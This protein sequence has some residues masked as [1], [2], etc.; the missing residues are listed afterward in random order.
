MK[1]DLKEIKQYLEST[2]EEFSDVYINYGI[3][4]D[5]E[6]QLIEKALDRVNE[7]LAENPEYRIAS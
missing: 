4:M 7:L 1:K 5:T 3:D 2:L 6:T